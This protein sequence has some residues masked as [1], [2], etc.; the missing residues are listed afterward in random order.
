MSEPVEILLLT[1]GWVALFTVLG[2]GPAWGL[3]RRLGSPVILAPVL[4]VAIGAAV[5]TTSALVLSMR[6]AA[7][8]V[9]V[10]MLLGSVVWFVVIV[11]R[12]QGARATV[13]DWKGAGIPAALCGCALVIGAM[14]NLLAGTLG[15]MTWVLRDAWWYLQTG[16]W[17]QEHSA[18]QLPT[19]D[20]YVTDLIGSSG[21][22]ILDHGGRTG[23]TAFYAVGSGL[24][25]IQPDRT[26]SAFLVA[27]FALLPASVWLV[28]RKLGGGRIAA[29]VAGA[30]VGPLALGLVV[31]SALANLT[32][33]LFIP[34]LL[35][36]VTLIVTERAWPVTVVAGIIAAGLVSSYPELVPFA[37]VALGG[38]GIVAIV[39]ARRAGR[40]VRGALR[41]LAVRIGV[42][43]FVLA[44]LAPYGVVQ[45]LNY[46]NDV[47]GAAP[48]SDVVDRGLSLETAGS[49]IFG[50]R[51]IYE[52]EFDSP[53]PYGGFGSAMAI[54]LPLALL[55]LVALGALAAANRAARAAVVLVPIV[56]AV[57]LGYYAYRS[58]ARGGTCQY[59]LGKG[60]T[61]AIPFIAVGIGLGVGVLLDG[62]R[63]GS[64]AYRLAAGAGLG[65]VVLAGIGI[66]LQALRAVDDY[67]SQAAYPPA[68]ARRLLR[69]G[70]P[71]PPSASV[72]M[73]GIED[74]G[75]A[76]AFLP[77]L[78]TLVKDAPGRR[79]YY[80][81]DWNFLPGLYLFSQVAFYGRAASAERYADP[82]Y[83]W[84]FSA[85]SGLDSGRERLG[86]DG[87]YAIER[88]APVDVLVA[89]A[90]QIIGGPDRRAS[91]AARPML[92]GP[93]E[94]WASSP[95]ARQ[96]YVVVE[97]DRPVTGRPDIRIGG[98]PA[99]VT[100]GNASRRLCIDAHLTPGFTRIHVQPPATY[101]TGISLTRVAGGTG[102]CRDV[103]AD[104]G[105]P[106][107]FAGGAYRREPLWF[108]GAGG[109]WLRS[110]AVL[111]VGND[112]AER[113]ATEVTLRVASFTRPRVVVAR[114]GDQVVG[115]VTA[116][117]RP[118]DAAPLVIRVPAGVG[119][120]EILFTSTPGDQPASI[121]NPSDPRVLA[122]LV[123]DPSVNL[124]R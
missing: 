114:M 83:E 41:P 118:D 123:S 50:L 84:V 44:A 38:A 47:S 104:W 122:V 4:G 71:L 29:T 9:L 35:L 54:I 112:G 121:A 101:E 5:F 91:Q 120:A 17:L 78:Y 110:N 18:R 13:R 76:V 21:A 117:I 87:R 96:G 8:V 99:K 15:P 94:L 105:E 103:T 57:V 64:S 77:G 27:V 24:A 52:L 39:A 82:R 97:T 81:A 65:V 80:D 45:L 55:A 113:A 36:S 33:I 93:F 75:D 69:A 68:E 74:T 40:D 66:G 115:R 2:L 86:V 70:G 43:V 32:A 89:R 102:S 56:V 92:R 98:R 12:D 25:G 31:D 28:A 23:V 49:W 48:S 58:G 116:P 30:V 90:N 67:A 88:R 108:G 22:L 107:F 19:A 20:G 111:E 11:Q 85:W 34:L 16:E 59:C 14:P 100:W 73:E 72:F 63:R 119:A 37:V 95:D 26:F 3:G 7:F 10:P 124:A 79:P 61:L 53:I 1:L 62:L 51:H 60:L 6:V 109:R 106:V 46:L 42:G